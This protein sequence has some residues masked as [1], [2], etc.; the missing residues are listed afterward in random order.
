[1]VP[2]WVPESIADALYDIESRNIGYDSLGDAMEN[3]AF[4]KF[5][6]AYSKFSLRREA[7][8]VLRELKGRG[9]KLGLISNTHTS[10]PKEVLEESGLSEYFDAALYSNEEGIEKPESGLFVRAAMRVGS[11]PEN[12]AY[13]GNSKPLDYDGSLN[14]GYAKAVLV[15][16]KNGIKNLRELLEIFD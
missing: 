7:K 10:A 9:Y 12:C 3:P 2:S 5:S 15:S 6:K 16:G 4:R 8:D 1:L 11:K 13:V 14:A